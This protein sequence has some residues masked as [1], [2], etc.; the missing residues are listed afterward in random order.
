MSAPEFFSMIFGGAF[1]PLVFVLL[2][3]GGIGATA[4]IGRSARL[5]RI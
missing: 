1:G 2:G 3:V 4:L 5:R